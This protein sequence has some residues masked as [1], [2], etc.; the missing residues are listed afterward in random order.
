[1]ILWHLCR[2]DLS[3][4]PLLFLGINCSELALTFFAWPPRVCDQASDQAWWPALF[5]TVHVHRGWCALSCSVRLFALGAVCA[6]EGRQFFVL[7]QFDHFKL[8]PTSSTVTWSNDSGSFLTDDIAF[9]A[10]ILIFD[11]GEFYICQWMFRRLYQG[12]RQMLV[13]W[14]RSLERLP[15]KHLDYLSFK[16]LEKTEKKHS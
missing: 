16:T 6:K 13:I 7:F 12:E 8:S 5:E 3:S 15:V 11:N 2:V 9:H 14:S 10:F 4:S 1:M